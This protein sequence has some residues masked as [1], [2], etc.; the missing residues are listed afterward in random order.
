MTFYGHPSCSVALIDCTTLRSRFL[1]TPPVY[2]PEDNLNRLNIYSVANHF[3]PA[4]RRKFINALNT[5]GNFECSMTYEESTIFVGLYSTC[6]FGSSWSHIL[7][8]SSIR[9]DCAELSESSFTV[10]S[11]DTLSGAFLEAFNFMHHYNHLASDNWN[12]EDPSTIKQYLDKASRLGDRMM[13]LIGTA[14]DFT[15]YS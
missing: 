10:H 6:G 9:E 7:T 13:K 14:Y 4:D 3:A 15:G 12:T 8:L 11:H 1:R 5:H 2:V